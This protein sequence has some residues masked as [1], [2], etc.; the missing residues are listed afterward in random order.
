MVFG[1]DGSWIAIGGFSNVLNVINVP[2]CTP[3][4]PAIDVG[5]GIRGMT[6]SPDGKW[7]ATA[8]HGGRDRLVLL[9]VET[10]KWTRFLR[11]G[12]RLPVFS[13]DGRWLATSGNGAI[14]L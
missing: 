3:K 5:H 9:N 7:I 13:R 14:T 1:P 2:D 4:F 12:D 8:S 10:G 11:K 6:C